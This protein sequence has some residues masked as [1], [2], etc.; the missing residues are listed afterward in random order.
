VVLHKQRWFSSGLKRVVFE[1]AAGS[2]KKSLERRKDGAA[3][4]V[5]ELYATWRSIFTEIPN[6]GY[7][8]WRAQVLA[9]H[10]G[11]TNLGARGVSLTAGN[12]HDEH[13][14]HPHAI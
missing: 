7:E 5:S 8:F 2:S 11:G 10:G 1:M 13:S 4:P 6:F 9:R 3:S 12:S 14:R